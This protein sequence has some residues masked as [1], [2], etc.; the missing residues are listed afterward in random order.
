[1]QYY[2]CSQTMLRQHTIIYMANFEK[3]SPNLDFEVFMLHNWGMPIL[4]KA[5]QGTGRTLANSHVPI[6]LLSYGRISIPSLMSSG[7]RF[8]V[9][10]CNNTIWWK[11]G[12]L[13]CFTPMAYI[14]LGV[15]ATPL[16]HQET[17]VPALDCSYIALWIAHLLSVMQDINL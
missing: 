13:S 2:Y 17:N 10:G 14:I 16:V 3:R 12:F 6:E 11:Y 8:I 9:C 5:L 15:L 7:D 1:M 4:P